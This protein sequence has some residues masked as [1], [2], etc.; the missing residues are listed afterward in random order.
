MNWD[1]Y[2]ARLVK[3][4]EDSI[5]ETANQLDENDKICS[6]HY[7]ISLQD[8]ITIIIGTFKTKKEFLDEQR[9]SAFKGFTPEVS[10][11]RFEEKM[12]IINFYDQLCSLSFDSSFE[13]GFSSNTEESA[14][15]LNDTV[16]YNEFLVKEVKGAIEAQLSLQNSEI[17]KH[18]KVSDHL[19]LT[20]SMAQ[21]EP[22]LNAI[23]TK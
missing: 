20:Y 14:E 17:I 1:D 16:A 22:V 5:E 11:S 13:T 9:K 15:L 8:V 19:E 6:I 2:K 12:K 21:G 7:W 10:V 18:E 4:T 23:V 3:A